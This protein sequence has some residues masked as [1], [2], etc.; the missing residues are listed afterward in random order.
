MIMFYA[1]GRVENGDLVAVARRHGA[2]V[3]ERLKSR[4]EGALLSQKKEGDMFEYAPIGHTHFWIRLR[5]QFYR[6]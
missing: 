1:L 5:K 6:R 3:P 4:M 2:N